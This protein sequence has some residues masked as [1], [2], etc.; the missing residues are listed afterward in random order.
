MTSEMGKIV[1]QFDLFVSTL[2]H[3]I[4]LVNFRTAFIHLN[5]S[6][7]SLHPKLFR[8]HKYPDLNLVFHGRQDGLQEFATYNPPGPTKPGA[9]SPV[10]C[11]ITKN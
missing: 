10:S 4:F 8:V 9:G 6:S 3:I 2:Y 1:L 7:Y 5:E 11:L